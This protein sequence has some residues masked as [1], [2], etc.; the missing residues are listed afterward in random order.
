M[1][2]NAACATPVRTY[3]SVPM[4]VIAPVAPA[5]NITADPGI[6]VGKG[7]SVTFTATVTNS[8]SGLTYQW[9]LNN[10]AIV[11]ET[12]ANFTSSS[13][14]DKDLVSCE[15]TSSGICVVSATAAGMQMDVSSEGVTSPQPS[16]K[17]REM[18]SVFPN[19]A[20]DEVII[21]HAEGGEV[22]IY[23]LPGQVILAF[24]KLRI[25]SVREVLNV[26]HLIPGIYIVQVIKR[27]GVV[28]NVRLVIAQ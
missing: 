4:S 24:D 10:V 9:L 12:H 3:T 13:I 22:S 17:E 1:T 7:Q 11:G 2:S 26:S 18:V 6:N 25:R 27:N 20:H 19:P 14:T 8:V 23:D 16:P 15:V 21:E 28:K 5:I